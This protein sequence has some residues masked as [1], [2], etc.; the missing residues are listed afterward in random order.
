MSA[1]GLPDLVDSHCPPTWESFEGDLDA[2]VDRMRAAGVVQAVVVG[3]T[4]E[5]SRRVELLCRD[6]AGL[7]PA[8]GIHP[9][10]VPEAADAALDELEA[11]VRSGGFVAVGE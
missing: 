11:L 7:Y 4:V 8:A 10:D 9:N 2:T 6:R 1:D 5:D 3:T